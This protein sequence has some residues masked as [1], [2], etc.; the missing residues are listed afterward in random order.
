MT[1]STTDDMLRRMADDDIPPIM[2]YGRE[3][4]QQKLVRLGPFADLIEAGMFRAKM[5]DH[6][7]LVELTG[8]NQAAALG[9]IYGRAYGGVHLLVREIDEP[10]ARKIIADVEERRRERLAKE[11]PPCPKCRG[12]NVRRLVRKSRLVG[13][14]LV[15][16]FPFALLHVDPVIAAVAAAF[17]VM[18]LYLVF[19]ARLPLWRCADCRTGYE[20]DMPDTLED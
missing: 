7:I 17:G 3:V 5:E 20:A 1:L 6:G 9:A 16:V 14:L 13:L 4:P 12:Y 11:N 10:A 18:G 19:R 2:D 8:E 15:V